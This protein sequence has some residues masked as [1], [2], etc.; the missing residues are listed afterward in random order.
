MVAKKWKD[1]NKTDSEIWSVSIDMHFLSSAHK[2]LEIDKGITTEV[3]LTSSIEMHEV[4]LPTASL[5]PRPSPSPVLVIILQVIKS[6]RWGRQ[7][8]YKANC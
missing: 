2:Q 7:L 5:V 1:K 8:G 6:W 4:G 3:A